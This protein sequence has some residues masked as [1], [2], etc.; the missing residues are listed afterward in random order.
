[1]QEVDIWGLIFQL[2]A[3]AVPIIFIV[4]LSLSWRSSKN[5]KKQFNHI[6]HKLNSMEKKIKEFMGYPDHSH[7]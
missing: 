7:G 3:L 6:D 1:M 5:R 4:I 2:I